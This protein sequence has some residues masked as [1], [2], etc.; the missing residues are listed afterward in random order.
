VKSALENGL[1]AY[2][3]I[4]NSEPW[5]VL[6]NIVRTPAAVSKKSLTVE[7]TINGKILATSLIKVL[8][9]TIL[10]KTVHCAS[11]NIFFN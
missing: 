1:S 3:E 6:N 8:R 2:Q 9:K 7:F 11:T 10:R 4:S 5:L